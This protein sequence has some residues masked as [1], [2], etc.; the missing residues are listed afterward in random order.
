LLTLI[1]LTK[2]FLLLVTV[3]FS[4]EWDLKSLILLWSEW[5]VIWGIT[6]LLPLLGSVEWRSFI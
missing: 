6:F 4:N 5:V 3:S 2:K 1:S